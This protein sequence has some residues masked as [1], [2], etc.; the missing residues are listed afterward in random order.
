MEEKINKEHQVCTSDGAI[1]SHGHPAVRKK[2]GDCVAAILILGIYHS[3]LQLY[4][5]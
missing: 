2:T 1:D 5:Q 4:N 3:T